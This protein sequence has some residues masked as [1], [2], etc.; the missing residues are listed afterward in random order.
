MRHPI[1]S[2]SWF[3]CQVCR[4]LQNSFFLSFKTSGFASFTFWKAFPYQYSFVSYVHLHFKAKRSWLAVQRKTFSDLQTTLPTRQGSPCQTTFFYFGSASF[5]LTLYDT[6][7]WKTWTSYFGFIA[8]FL[9]VEYFVHLD[10]ILKN[11]RN[12]KLVSI[13]NTSAD[14]S[15]CK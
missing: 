2:K 8:I 12:C 11:C 15:G 7:R 3:S 5:L 1:L 6:S 10:I 9:T 4:Y 13:S 14:S